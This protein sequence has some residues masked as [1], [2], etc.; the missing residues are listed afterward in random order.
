VIEHTLAG[1]LRRSV[2]SNLFSGSDSFYKANP[3]DLDTTIVNEPHW[4]RGIPWGLR[5]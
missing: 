2:I 4:L 1:S 3:D 5:S